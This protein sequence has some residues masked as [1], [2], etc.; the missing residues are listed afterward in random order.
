MP[1]RLTEAQAR[2]LLGKLPGAPRR[3][4]RRLGP[5]LPR[6]PSRWEEELRFQLIGSGLREGIDFQR[7]AQLIPG[8]KSRCDFALPPWRLVVEIEGGVWSAGRHSRGRGFT[9]D[10]RK[11][12]AL[13]KLGWTVLRYVPEDVENGTAI[14]DI[15]EVVLGKKRAGPAAPPPD[16]APAFRP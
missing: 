9:E 11:Y 5:R 14:D 15:L 1:L 2:A 3:S 6:P 4:G 12:N 10:T 13:R 8:R 7:E 16:P